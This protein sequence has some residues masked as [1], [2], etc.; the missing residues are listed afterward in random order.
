M[1]T[2]RYY[3]F[4]S[5]RQR[6]LF[7][8]FVLGPWA[9]AVL[10]TLRILAPAPRADSTYFALHTLALTALAGLVIWVGAR[11]DRHNVLWGLLALITMAYVMVAVTLAYFLQWRLFLVIHLGLALA[12]S[13][14]ALIFFVVLRA[15]TRLRHRGIHKARQRLKGDEDREPVD[16]LARR[17]PIV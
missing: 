12:V 13:L 3:P 15:M 10:V 16:W 9:V 17:R 2:I 6:R 14:A 1:N 4:L 8:W 5:G 7:Q 11:A